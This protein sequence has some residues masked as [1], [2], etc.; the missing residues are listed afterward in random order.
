MFG[1]FARRDDADHVAVG[2]LAVAD[3]EE[4]GAA[5]HAKQE[6]ALFLS[7]MQIVVELDGKLVV[8]HGSCI[9][10]RSAILPDVRFSLGPI[11]LKC[12]HLYIVWITDA[13]ATFKRLQVFLRHQV[14]AA[15]S[16]AWRG[17]IWMARG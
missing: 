12:D 13:L 11:L 15:T 2:A 1:G 7:R 14:T 5:A 16:S 6:E 9:F 3:E 8:E 10:E 17:C 4:L